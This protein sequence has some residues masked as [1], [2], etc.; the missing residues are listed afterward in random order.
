MIDLDF[1]LVFILPRGFF[2]FHNMPFSLS[3]CLLYTIRLTVNLRTADP[4][5]AQ[6]VG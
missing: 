3:L 2:F 5:N 6:I 1:A 4:F